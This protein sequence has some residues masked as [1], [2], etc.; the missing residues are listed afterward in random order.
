MGHTGQPANPRNGSDPGL[1][2]EFSPFGFFM[3][4]S[5][6]NLRL[7]LNDLRTEMCNERYYVL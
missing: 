1:S 3:R 4:L 7:G 5:L 2:E 6:L